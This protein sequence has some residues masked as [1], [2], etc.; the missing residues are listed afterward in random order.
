[1]IYSS[2]GLFHFYPYRDMEGKFPGGCHK[3]FPRESRT[4]I[5]FPRGLGQVFQRDKD[6]SFTEG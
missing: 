6:T 3:H 2:V 5:I 1:M 4:K